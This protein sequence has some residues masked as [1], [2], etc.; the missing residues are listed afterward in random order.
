MAELQHRFADR[1][2]DSE[3]V[4]LS[5]APVALIVNEAKRRSADYIVMG[6]HGHTSLYDLLVGST[7]HGVFLHAPCPVVIVPSRMQTGAKVASKT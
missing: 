1:N 6:S 3:I 5:G 7:T 2:I 4:Q